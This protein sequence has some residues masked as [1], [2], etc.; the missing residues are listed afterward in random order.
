MSKVKVK[1]E[2]GAIGSSANLNRAASRVESDDEFDELDD[3]DIEDVRNRKKRG[4]M[5]TSGV[6]AAEDEDQA[7]E[8]DD[9]DDD[10]GQNGSPN[11]RKRARINEDGDATPVKTEEQAKLPLRV[12]LP[13]DRDG[14]VRLYD[15]P[16]EV[17]D[18]PLR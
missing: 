11:G 5:L 3:L 15:P 1:A 12:T 7:Q 9:D 17:I 10:D 14:S 13:R 4:S 8:I 18:P 16:C 2:L 6:G